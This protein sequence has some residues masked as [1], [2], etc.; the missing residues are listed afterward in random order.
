M[1]RVARRGPSEL[2][3]FGVAVQKEYGDKPD[4]WC[5]QCWTDEVA[6]WCPCPT[7]TEPVPQD[8]TPSDVSEAVET[9]RTHCENKVCI[10][11]YE[12]F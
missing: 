12:D 7:A 6:D 9:L 5:D 4:G 2:C 11:R 10:C 1:C 3:P 8:F